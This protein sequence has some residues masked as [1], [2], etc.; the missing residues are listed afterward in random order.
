M[1]DTRSPKPGSPRVTHFVE[2][3]TN[4]LS[5]DICED[6]IARFEADPR[7]KPSRT[8]SRSNPDIRTGTMLMPGGPEWRDVVELVDKVIRTHLKDYVQKYQG[9][10]LVVSPERSIISEP[11]I[12]KIEPGQRY[13]YHI[14]SGMADTHDRVLSTLIY[15]RDIDEGGFTEFPYQSVRA[16][17]QA[18][19]MLVF[20]PFWTHVHRG[21]SPI[22]GTKYNIT[23]F[24]LIRPRPAPPESAD[25]KETPP[26]P[27][28]G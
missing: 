11:L 22:S 5:K 9:A 13:G 26:I 14:D 28:P 6:I 19:S 18:G 27:P 21:V 20:P 1:A 12:E 4:A 2:V 25:A 24:V 8:H 15:L 10:Q 7:T 3:Y 16:Q 17:P 23:N